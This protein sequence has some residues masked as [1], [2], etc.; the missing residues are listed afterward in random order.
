M[1]RLCGE[2][3][4]GGERGWVRAKEPIGSSSSILAD[5]VVG[6]AWCTTSGEG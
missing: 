1:E 6:K 3:G 4:E 2:S 5:R